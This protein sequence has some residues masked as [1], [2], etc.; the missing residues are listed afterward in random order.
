MCAWWP[1]TASAP[2]SIATRATSA[3]Y[4]ASFART[5][6]RPLCSATTTKSLCERNAAMS[7]RTAS[8][9][10]GERRDVEADP[11]ERGEVIGV[12]GTR[13]H[14]GALHCSAAR[15]R[16]LDVSD[17]DIARPE[18]LRARLEQG[19]RIRLVEDQVAEREDLHQMT[20]S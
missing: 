13:G 4:C 9:D 15:V 16:H 11:R 6:P 1:T 12:G 14:V 17:Q 3:S 2:A 7:A 8:S 19:I 20:P 18:E 10:S 5:W